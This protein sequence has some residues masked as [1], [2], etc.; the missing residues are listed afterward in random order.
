MRL[1]TQ[2]LIFSV[3]G[4]A[5]AAAALLVFPNALSPSFPPSLDQIMRVFFW[6]VVLCEHLVGRGPTIGP[7][8][9]HLHE[10]TPVHLLAAVVGLPENVPSFRAGNEKF[11]TADSQSR[12][13]EVFVVRP[14]A[15][16]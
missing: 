14:T 7:P 2:W 5:V 8:N 4:G 1:R 16:Q 15:Q 10:G 9:R 12:I 3:R 6:P 13:K 11:N